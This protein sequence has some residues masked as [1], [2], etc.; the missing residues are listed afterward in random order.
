MDTSI[1]NLLPARVA[2]RAET[3]PGVTTIRLRVGGAPLLAR[4][5]TRSANALALVEGREVFAQVKGVAVVHTQ[6][7]ARDRA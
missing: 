4:V 3:G 5:T 1:L 7:T 2:H 6:D